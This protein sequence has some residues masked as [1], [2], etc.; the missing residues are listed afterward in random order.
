MPLHQ[1]P[2]PQPTDTRAAWE[3]GL[4]AKSTSTKLRRGPRQDRPQSWRPLWPALL[5]VGSGG[6]VGRPDV[7]PYLLS[8]VESPTSLGG[9][10]LVTDSGS[11]GG[12]SAWVYVRDP[13][14][15]GGRPV[16]IG[17][18]YASDASPKIRAVV[19]SRDGSIAA[20]RADVG[21]ARGKHFVR[22]DGSFL[23]AAYDFRFHHRVAGDGTV[24]GTSALLSKLMRRRGGSGVVVFRTPYDASGR[25]MSQNQVRE[26]RT[27]MD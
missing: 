6:C 14:G 2:L 5:L 27:G 22:L 12:T 26:Y 9:V 24:R 1:T 17:G 20:V 11:F 25:P 21:A 18:P 8:L 16:L 15:A 19:W 13:R 7:T 10:S 23:V 3:R 4:S